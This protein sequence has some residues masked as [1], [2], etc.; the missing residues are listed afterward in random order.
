MRG[1]N[2]MIHGHMS[3]FMYGLQML[4]LLPVLAEVLLLAA[5]TSN[6]TPPTNE[7]QSPI[8]IDQV[9]AGTVAYGYYIAAALMVGV[10]I[11]NFLRDHLFD[12]FGPAALVIFLMYRIRNSRAGSSTVARL[13]LQS[14]VVF[15]LIAA[16]AI[17]TSGKHNY[18]PVLYAALIGGWAFP[19]FIRAAKWISKE[20]S[21]GTAADAV[22]KNP[23][24]TDPGLN[25]PGVSSGTPPASAPAHAPAAQG[26]A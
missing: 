25:Q 15:G 7:T 4:W 21:K 17:F 11:P 3:E 23:A 12:G 18:V 6:R 1:L 24:E 5:D 9:V 26:Q 20:N 10:Q 2:M 13:Y 19:L 16:A 22:P 14:A 8:G